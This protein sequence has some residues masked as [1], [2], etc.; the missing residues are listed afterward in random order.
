MKQF[1]TQKNATYSRARIDFKWIFPSPQ[2]PPIL[3]YAV[4]I[5][6]FY[7]ALQNALSKLQP[8]MCTFILYQLQKG[9]G[10]KF[11]CSSIVT[12]STVL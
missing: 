10:K 12:A 9:A 7:N 8:F 4:L 6:Q 3:D 11:I 2:S 1:L 5:L